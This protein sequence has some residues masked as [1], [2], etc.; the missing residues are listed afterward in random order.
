MS[1]INTIF[2]IISIASAIVT[3]VFVCKVAEEGRF[4]R[5]A[6]TATCAI[7]SILAAV[8][9]LPAAVV[10][11]IVMLTGKKVEFN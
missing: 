1:A 6:T 11:A 10:M 3:V 9:W 7:M 2:L 4:N 8:L 5:V